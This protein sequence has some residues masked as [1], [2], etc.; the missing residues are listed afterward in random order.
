MFQERHLPTR[1]TLAA[2]DFAG[3]LLLRNGQAVFPVEAARAS[4][5]PGLPSDIRVQTLAATAANLLRHLPGTRRMP[6]RPYVSVF[7][8]W[9]TGYAHFVAE[10]VVKI[11]QHLDLVRAA[12]L[13]VPPGAPSFVDQY[14]ELLGIGSVEVQEHHAWFPRLTIIE[15]SVPG[16]HDPSQVGAVRDLLAPVRPGADAPRELVYISRAKARFRKV[17]D[18]QRLTD[19]LRAHGFSSVMTDQMKVTEQISLFASARVLMSLNGAGLINMMFMRPGTTVI[20]L[21]PELVGR[22]R[23]NEFCWRLADALGLRYVGIVCRRDDPSQ[24]VH[25][26]DVHVDAD[27]VERAIRPLL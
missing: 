27:A 25:V 1:R 3:V 21:I 22:D 17:L 26:G 19:R 12:T 16:V 18:E 13:L 9:S 8:H 20:E 10:V 15:H 2:R 11:V 23:P 24:S 14:L 5:M 6:D 7:N 4:L